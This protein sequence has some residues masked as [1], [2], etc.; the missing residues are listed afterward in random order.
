VT[1]VHPG[2]RVIVN[3]ITRLVIAVERIQ[4][5]SARRILTFEDGTHY[6][7]TTYVQL[8]G[9]DRGCFTPP[10]RDGYAFEQAVAVRV[11]E[12]YNLLQSGGRPGDGGIDITARAMDDGH[13]LAVQCKDWPGS[14][15]GEPIIQRFISDAKGYA[16]LALVTTGEVSGPAIKLATK[17]SVTVIDYRRKDDWLAGKVALLRSE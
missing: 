1:H 7:S 2:D 13:L 16:E 11:A 6:N 4:N 17:E 9:P 10:R 8:V 15:V 3:G 12:H 14:P 5:I